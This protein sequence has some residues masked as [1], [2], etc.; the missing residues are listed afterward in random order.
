MDFFIFGINKFFSKFRTDESRFKP[1]RL[2]RQMGFIN[3]LLKPI[4]IIAGI[5][6]QCAQERIPNDGFFL[7]E[8]NR[9]NLFCFIKTLK[10]VIFFRK[11]NLRHKVNITLLSLI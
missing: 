5:Y 6:R 4:Q 9:K 2:F 10:L 8:Y 1:C 11:K 3:K 7:F